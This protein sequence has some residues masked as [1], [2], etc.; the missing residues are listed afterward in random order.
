MELL[1]ETK[2]S[3]IYLGYVLNNESGNIDKVAFAYP[4]TSGVIA[5]VI[6]VEEQV[7]QKTLDIDI[8]PLEEESKVSKPSRFTP[9]IPKRKAK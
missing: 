8:V 9:K 4:N 2:A 3:N 7:T 6:N 5:W 1:K